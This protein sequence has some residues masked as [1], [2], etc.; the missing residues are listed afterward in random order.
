MGDPFIKEQFL[1]AG[2]ISEDEADADSGETVGQAEAKALKRADLVEKAK[3]RITRKQF[4]TVQSVGKSK[5]C[6]SASH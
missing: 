6:P 5:V 3:R 1:E 4:F 2:D